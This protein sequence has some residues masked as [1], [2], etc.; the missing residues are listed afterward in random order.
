[1]RA[2]VRVD[3]RGPGP[4]RS[5]TELTCEIQRARPA[6]GI[7]YLAMTRTRHEKAI[8]PQREARKKEKGGREGQLRVRR[9]DEAKGREYTGEERARGIQAPKV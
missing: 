9:K 1:M 5:R 2:C 4:S 6:K 8:S 3:T 7:L